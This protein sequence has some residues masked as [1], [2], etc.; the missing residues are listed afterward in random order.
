MVIGGGV[1]VNTDHGMWVSMTLFSGDPAKPHWSIDFSLAGDG[2]DIDARRFFEGSASSSGFTRI[3]E[4]V[5]TFP[6]PY[7]AHSFERKE[8]FTRWF[9]FFKGRAP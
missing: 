8:R 6:D 7:Q 4:F 1:P 3:E 5:L 2:D 9:R